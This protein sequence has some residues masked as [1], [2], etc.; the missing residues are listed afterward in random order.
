MRHGRCR[1]FAGVGG[2][3][4]VFFFF[5]LNLLTE[6]H[7]CSF[8][9]FFFN[10]LPSYFCF[11]SIKIHG[12]CRCEPGFA[13]PACDSIL[14]SNLPHLELL[15]DSSRLHHKASA[16]IGRVGHS[17]VSCGNS[18]LY[19]FGGYHLEKGLL[20]DM[21][22]YNTVTGNWTQLHHPTK[23]HPRG[24]SVSSLC[25][26]SSCIHLEILWSFF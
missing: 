12:M 15:V 16:P 2:G 18:R 24:R 19:V 8:G 17:M 21:W 4:D 14:G 20:D 13:G 5:F 22:L 25:F 23:A 7:V 26:F 6:C 3:Q 11:F 9:L 1:Y 10:F